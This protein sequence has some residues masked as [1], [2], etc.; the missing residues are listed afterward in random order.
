MNYETNIYPM[1]L[2]LVSSSG[3]SS[4]LCVCVCDYASAVVASGRL[5]VEGIL[6]LLGLFVTGVLL[7]AELVEG[8]RV[9]EESADT[10]EALT[11]LRAGA[12]V[13]R[14][15]LDA[16]AEGLV[17]VQE[18]VQ[19]RFARDELALGELQRRASVRVDDLLL[20]GAVSLR[21]LFK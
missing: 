6:V 19:Q 9:A 7:V 15:E 18:P 5:E 21:K 2:C 1:A 13:V 16:T 8:E 11:E 3:C 14:Y 20:C 4:S 17:V 10:A 12:R